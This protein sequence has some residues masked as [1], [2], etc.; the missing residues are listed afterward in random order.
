MKILL[1]DDDPFIHH[2]VALWLN[3]NG[4]EVSSAYNGSEALAKLKESCFEGLITD[5]NM[6]LMKGIDLVKEVLQLPQ[7]PNLIV[8]LTS[9]CDT[10][11]LKKELNNSNVHL[12]NKPFSPSTLT[13]LIERLH[14]ENQHSNEHEQRKFTA[15]AT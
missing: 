3:R 9:R 13:E 14:K 10:G 4:H 2:I 12:F 5:V 15:D 1:A 6:P 11:Q 8:V 7:K